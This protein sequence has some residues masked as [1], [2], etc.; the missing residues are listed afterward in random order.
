MSIVYGVYWQHFR[1]LKVLRALDNSTRPLTVLKDLAVRVGRVRGVV[2]NF[3]APSE[4]SVHGP[5]TSF[6]N[7]VTDLCAGAVLPP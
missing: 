5:K 4:T 3:E 6:A 7:S 2:C 1:F